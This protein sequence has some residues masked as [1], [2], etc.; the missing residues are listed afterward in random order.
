MNSESFF[1]IHYSSFDPEYIFWRVTDGPTMAHVIAGIK[2][3]N[4]DETELLKDWELLK[5]LNTLP[6]RKDSMNEQVFDSK[7]LVLELM[8]IGI[9]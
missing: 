4:S 8:T 3:K 6:L 1:V 2:F 9:V 5:Y 7:A